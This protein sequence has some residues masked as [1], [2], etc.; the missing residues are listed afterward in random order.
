[1]VKEVHEW[2]GSLVQ[3]K[4]TSGE[5]I[6]KSDHNRLV[7]EAYERGSDNPPMLIDPTS[8]R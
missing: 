8:G 7:Q 3:A 2:L 6:T 1:M 4:I 5:L